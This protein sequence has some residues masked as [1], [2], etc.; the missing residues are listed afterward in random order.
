MVLVD[1]FRPLVRV[2]VRAADGLEGLAAAW[3]RL[4]VAAVSVD[5]RPGFVL[6]IAL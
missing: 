2:M 4:D 6:L 1:H 5:A 3:G